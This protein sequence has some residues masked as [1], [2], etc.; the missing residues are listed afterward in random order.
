LI[1]FPV[2]INVGDRGLKEGKVELKRRTAI[3]AQMV[4]IEGITEAARD[5]LTRK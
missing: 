4:P 2:R 1:G 5:A 3:E